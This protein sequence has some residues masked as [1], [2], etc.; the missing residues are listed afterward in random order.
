MACFFLVM[1]KDSSVYSVN[2]NIKSNFK[3]VFPIDYFISHNFSG[4]RIV[5][6]KAFYSKFMPIL[7]KQ[8]N[9]RIK[10]HNFRKLEIIS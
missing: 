3:N 9:H 5:P 6:N 1:K 7:E 8:E 10:I 2:P 4:N